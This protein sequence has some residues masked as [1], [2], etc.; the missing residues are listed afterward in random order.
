MKLIVDSG[1]TKAD[2]RLIHNDNS[3]KEFQTIGLNPFIAKRESIIEA[4]KNID[5]PLDDIQQL[6]FY[7]AGCDNAKKNYW[8]SQILTSMFRQS[9]IYVHSDLLAS[10]HALLG[11]KSGTIGILGTGS[12]AAFYDGKKI[13][14]F[15]TSLGYLLGDEGS[16]NALGKK[17]L[18][19]ILTDK[20]DV[21][22]SSHLK[23][24]KKVILSELYSHPYPNRYLASF[25][26]IIFQFREHPQIQSII[27]ESF[28]EFI[29]V[30]LRPFS[31]KTISFT[32]SIA[33]YYSNELK[34]CCQ[35]HQIEILDIIEK[36][37]SALTQFHLEYH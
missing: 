36:P 34:A 11:T 14:L 4:I 19:S 2:W 25:A 7:G 6:Y 13:H 1:S 15:T 29:D 30:Y 10:A 35:N 5:L 26:K 24:D 21:E 20:I 37:I 18:K 31:K 12:N 17:F 23:L 3:I 32:G 16:G 22:I 9:K 27:Y 33:H 28:N 8:L